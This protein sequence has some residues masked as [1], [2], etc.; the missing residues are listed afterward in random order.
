MDTKAMNPVDGS[1]ANIR[2]SLFDTSFT[3]YASWMLYVDTVD[4]A[5]HI[6]WVPNAL[7]EESDPQLA[8]D[9]TISEL[10]SEGQWLK[11]GTWSST[12]H[13]DITGYDDTFWTYTS[14]ETLPDAVIIA[15]KIRY[16]LP[17]VY[18]SPVL[19]M[20]NLPASYY[21]PEH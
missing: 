8:A 7:P 14:Q 17:S 16:A 13:Y 19:F 5:I 1:F 18:Q 15:G 11:T 2:F 4:R 10:T 20:I 12:E 3:Y 9:V 21:L 6:T